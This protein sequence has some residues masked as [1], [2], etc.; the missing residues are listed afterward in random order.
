MTNP[1]D[2]AAQ[3]SK[4]SVDEGREQ[5]QAPYA[6]ATGCLQFKL[7][8]ILTILKNTNEKAYLEALSRL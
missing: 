5:S 1:Y 6:Y 4:A 2:A 7:G 8:E 3:F